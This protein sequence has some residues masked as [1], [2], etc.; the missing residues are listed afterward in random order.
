[1][2]KKTKKFIELLNLTTYPIIE[3]INE[4]AVEDIYNNMSIFIK[5]KSNMIFNIQNSLYSKDLEFCKLT[6]HNHTIP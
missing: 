3:K 5:T 6:P 1:M 2:E 4:K